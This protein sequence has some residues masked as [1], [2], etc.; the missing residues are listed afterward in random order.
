RSPSTG[1]SI[2]SPRAASR[3]SFRLRWTTRRRCPPDP[4]WLPVLACEA[5]RERLRQRV[6]RMMAA[7]SHL[8]GRRDGY[9]ESALRKSVATGRESRSNAAVRHDRRLVSRLEGVIGSSGQIGL[10]VLSLSR[11]HVSIAR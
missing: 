3:R 11:N 8:L 6:L 7:P 10:A 9:I 5:D 4:A 1:P 2:S